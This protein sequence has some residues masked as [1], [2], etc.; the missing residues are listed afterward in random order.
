M[1]SREEFEETAVLR[2]YATRGN[3]R[4]YTKANPK[5]IYTEED[6]I[7]CYRYDSREQSKDNGIDRWEKLYHQTE[8]EKMQAKR[9]SWL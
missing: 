9:D 1:Y 5:T 3:A 2:G 7:D 6:L 4:L 8:D